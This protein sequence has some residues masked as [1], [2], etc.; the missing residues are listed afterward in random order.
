VQLVARE[1]DGV[2]LV[3]SFAASWHTGTDEHPANARQPVESMPVVSNK[4][5]D[6]QRFITEQTG[7]L[8]VNS[9]AQCTTVRVWLPF[10]G[11]LANEARSCA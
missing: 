3:V 7:K 2:E 11:G 10:G 8:V 9:D 5:D 1:D 4:L 6:L